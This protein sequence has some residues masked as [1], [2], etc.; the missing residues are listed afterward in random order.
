MRNTAQNWPRPTARLRSD[1]DLQS[2]QSPTGATQEIHASQIVGSTEY[3]RFIS[4]YLFLLE[5]A[6]ITFLEFVKS[7]FIP[8]H[9]L[10]KSAAGKRHYHAM[11]KHIL[12]PT[13]V[14]EL[15]IQ[16]YRKGNGRLQPDLGWPYLDDVRLCEVTVDHIKALISAALKNGYSIQTVTHIRNVVGTILTHATNT[17]YFTGRNPAYQVALPT[18]IRKPASRLNSLYVKQI[19]GRMQNPDRQIAL[20]AIFTG[21]TLEEICSLQW[22]QINVT[23]LPSRIKKHYLPPRTIAVYKQMNAGRFQ[24]TQVTRIKD[25]RISDVPLVLLRTLHSKRACSNPEDLVFSSRNGSALTAEYLSDKLMKLGTELR[26]PW[27]SW[28]LLTKA[29]TL[30]TK[31]P[32][33]IEKNLQSIFLLD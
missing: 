32:G 1:K 23:E 12:N 33:E 4:P 24:G 29:H 20:I 18:M 15:F 19:L 6:K 30:L 26:M 7:R 9:V 17:H 16:D 22:K 8:E 21:L 25:V 31:T 28:K 3:D 5:N 11:L 10:S 14:S 13:T 2:S 27:L